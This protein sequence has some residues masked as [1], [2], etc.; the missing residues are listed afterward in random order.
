MIRNP[1]F[2]FFA[3][4]LSLLLIDSV[5]LTLIGEKFMAMIRQIQGAQV[6]FRKWPAVICYILLSLAILFFIETPRR[7]V[8]YAFLLG[9][10]IYGVYETTSYA[11]LKKWDLQIAVMDTVWGGILFVLATI[12]SRFLVKW[13]SRFAK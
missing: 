3:I 6:E 5:Y 4:L 11:L 13:V 10:I 8:G 2:H 12:L 9:I 7:H 1:I